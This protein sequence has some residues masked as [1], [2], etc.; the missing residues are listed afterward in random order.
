MYLSE[1]RKVGVIVTT[2]FWQNAAGSQQLIA[3]GAGSGWRI[4][5]LSHWGQD[6]QYMGPFEN[7]A[8]SCYPNDLGMRR[9]LD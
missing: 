2:T 8:V 6:D 4:V 9:L 3:V 7:D 1:G 5:H